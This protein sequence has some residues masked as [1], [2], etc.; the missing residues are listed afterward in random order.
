MIRVVRVR[1][2]AK[3][4]LGLRVLYRRPDDYHELRTVFQTISLSDRIEIEFN[5]A[6]TTRISLEGAPE[7]SDNLMET[8]AHLALEAL[9]SRAEVRFRLT[10]LIPAGA[11]LGGASTDAA[12]VLLALPVLAGKVI[13]PDRLHELACQ[14]G[15]DVPFFLHGGSVLGMGRGEELYPLPDRTATRGLI[16]APGVPSSTRE[17][18]RGITGQLTSIRLQNKLNSFQQE[19]WRTVEQGGGVATHRRASGCRAENDFEE[20][21]F[22]RHP[23]LR[24]IKERL[25]RLGANPAAMTGSGSAIFGLFRDRKQFDRAAKEFKAVAQ[26]VNARTKA[27]E[28][29]NVSDERV[30]PISFVNRT[31]YRS[32]WLR[33]LKPYV[34]PNLWPPQSLSAR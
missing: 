29:Q 24:Q 2:F 16:V 3:L 19:V 31:S 9:E 26:A 30:F 23:E 32:A 15:S 7:I 27:V 11:G 5:S 6:R 8:A 13:A 12:A 21:V 28:N 17:A 14:A 34:K 10:K 22:A 33:A 1:A 4:N 25:Q 20:V 18:Y